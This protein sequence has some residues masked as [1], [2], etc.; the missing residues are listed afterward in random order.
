MLHLGPDEARL[1]G[2]CSAKGRLLASFVMWKPNAED[3]L[4]ACHASVLA[5]ALKRL[6]M[7]VMRAKC[8]LTD[9]TADFEWLGVCGD[10]ARQATAGLQPWGRS[11]VAGANWIR[12]P[13]ASGTSRAW[14]VTERAGDPMAQLPPDT[15]ALQRWQRLE[16]ESG[17]PVIEAAT[18]D[19][20]VPQMLNYELIGAVNFQKGCYPGQE[21][22]ARSQYRATAKRRAFL[23]TCDASAAAGQEVF[24]SADAAQ[25]AGMVVN[26]AELT[27]AA[28][29]AASCVALVEV[30]LSALDAGALH[31]G[32]ADGARLTRLPM[33]Y[34]VPMAVDGETGSAT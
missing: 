14:R 16:V 17:I 25:P 30:K 7:F 6:S 22:V 21:V 24:H 10:A 29:Q 33:P 15:A 34:D 31:L 2:Y 13:D 8:Q 26:A 12:L 3:V 11:E 27:H 19:R 32:T 9:A 20:F 28:G 4:L 5:A 1:A 23:F 18:V